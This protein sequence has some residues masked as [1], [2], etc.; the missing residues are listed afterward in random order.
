MCM[1]VCLCLSV[2]LCVR[3]LVCFCSLLHVCE[4][5]LLLVSLHM[6]ELGACVRGARAC[7]CASVGMHACVRVR[8]CVRA[9]VG[10]RACVRARFL[11]HY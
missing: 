10:M 9:S 2:C 4:G 7:A 5:V 6:H 8:A 11:S 1:L 3:V